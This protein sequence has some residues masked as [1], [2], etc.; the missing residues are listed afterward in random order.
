LAGDGR[1]PASVTLFKG[2]KNVLARSDL[3]RLQCAIIK[4]KQLDATERSQEAGIA[5]VAAS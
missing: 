5:A 1:R 3:E 4:N 2:H